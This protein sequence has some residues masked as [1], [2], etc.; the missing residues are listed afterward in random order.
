MISQPFYLKRYLFILVGLNWVNLCIG[1]IRS[2]VLSFNMA[3]SIK[4]VVVIGTRYRD[5]EVKMP[6]NLCLSTHEG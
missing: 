4:V 1:P 3:K 6:S 5:I 2:Y